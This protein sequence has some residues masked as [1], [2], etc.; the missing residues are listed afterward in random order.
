V[1]RLRHGHAWEL[2]HAGDAGVSREAALVHRVAVATDGQSLPASALKP[3][4]AQVTG[5]RFVSDT[6][7]LCWDVR[8]KERGAVTVDAARSK[9]VIGFVGGKRFDLAGVV[10]EPGATQQAGWSAITVTAMEGEFGKPPCRMLIT[11]TGSAENTKMGWKGP[12]KNTVGIDWG[13]APTLVEGIPAR[14]TLPFAA[15]AVEVWALDACGQ[16]KGRLAVAAGDD[17]N[18]AVAL[19]PEQQTIWYEAVAR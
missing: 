14:L 15:R 10:I 16:R 7:E 19:G 11:A 13:E 4:Q 9:A 6:S 1:E 5:D 17:G 3:E 18:A 12:E 8:D 2:V